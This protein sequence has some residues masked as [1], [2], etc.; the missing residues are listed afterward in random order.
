MTVGRA[1]ISN[2]TKCS[3]VVRQRAS[4]NSRSL[5]FFTLLE[6]LVFQDGVR[7]I[8]RKC[9]VPIGCVI[10]ARIVG[11]V[12]VELCHVAIFEI[13]EIV[14]V[15][16]RE[17]LLVFGAVVGVVFGIKRPITL[18]VGLLLHALHSLVIEEFFH[19]S[20]QTLDDIL[21]VPSFT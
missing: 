4:T 17:R 8:R 3:N 6:I 9:V 13:K 12:V 11:D 14:T 5:L 16:I 2:V 7:R 10:A 19:V 15:A 1:G 21:F 20:H 18:V